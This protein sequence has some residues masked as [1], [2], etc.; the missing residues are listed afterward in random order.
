MVL[1]VLGRWNSS[2]TSLQCIFRSVYAK[3]A[4]M[5]IAANLTFAARNKCVE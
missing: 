5:C 4:K 3:K 2:I 1:D